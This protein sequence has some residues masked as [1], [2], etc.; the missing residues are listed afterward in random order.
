MISDRAIPLA[1]NQIHGIPSLRIMISYNLPARRI[2]ASLTVAGIL[3]FPG[4][5]DD[6]LGKRYP[7]SGTVTYNGKPVEKATISFVPS[8][9][10]GRGA[11][12]EITDGTYTLT[13]QSPGDGA[14]P[15]TYKVLIDSR[16]VDMAKVE[17]GSQ[18]LAAKVGIQTKQVDPALIAKFRKTAK[19]SIPTKYSSATDSNL[20]AEVKA[21]SNTIP[22]TLA[23]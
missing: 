22:F 19:S 4:C 8:T 3:A 1:Y 16:A 18:K 12:G 15:G 11:S 2:L 10:E 14:F 6:G 5:S 13:T 23:D 20:T 7:V 17:E 9:G 21:E